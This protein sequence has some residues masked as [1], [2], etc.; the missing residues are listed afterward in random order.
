MNLEG[1]G[2]TLC[3]ADESSWIDK[4]TFDNHDMV[5]YLRLRVRL[6]FDLLDQLVDGVDRRV[7]AFEAF[8]F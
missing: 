8:N 3:D 7:N 4:E 2:E 5:T 6:I 1:E